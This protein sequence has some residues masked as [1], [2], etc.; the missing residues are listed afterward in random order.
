MRGCRDGSVDLA[1][2]DVTEDPVSSQNP[3]GSSKLPI[4]PLP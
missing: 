4:T 3:H 1:L 2:A